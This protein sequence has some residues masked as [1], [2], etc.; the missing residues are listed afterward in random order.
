MMA[1][2]TSDTVDEID[3]LFHLDADSVFGD[4]PYLTGAAMVE[5]VRHTFVNGVVHLD[6]N[7][8]TDVI[9]SEVVCTTRYM[10]LLEAF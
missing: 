9:G 5:L 2:N 6:I 8:I 4:V 3:L 1:R 10:S 7:V